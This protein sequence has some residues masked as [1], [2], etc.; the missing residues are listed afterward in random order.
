MVKRK[1][2]MAWGGG[3]VMAV[4]VAFAWRP[5][6]ST[7]RGML[8]APM[9]GGLDACVLTPDLLRKQ[10]PDTTYTRLC[11]AQPASPGELV[12][13]TL[14]RLA[15]ADEIS[16]GGLRMGYTLNVPLLRLYDR[17]AEGFVLNPDRVRRYV[18]TVRDAGYPVILYLY[19]NHFGSGSELEEHL[20]ADSRNLLKSPAGVLPSDQFHAV[21]VRPWSFVEADNEITRLRQ[22]AIEA[23]LG[24]LCN[25]PRRAIQKVEGVTLLGELHHLFPDFNAG[26]G[27]LDRYLVSDYS[28]TSVQGF[29]RYLAQR[30]GAVSALNEY[31]GGQYANFEAVQ[32]P[33]KDIR[34]QALGS[35]FEHLDAYAHGQL[36]VSGWIGQVASGSTERP[37][38]RIYVDGALVGRVRADK[39]RQDVLLA[40]PGLK[41]A[42][43][44]WNFA[45]DFSVLPAGVHSVSVVLEREGVPTVLLTR[46]HISVMDRQQSTPKAQPELPIAGLVP[47]PVGLLFHQDEPRDQ[48]AYYFNPLARLWLEYRRT[49]VMA[50]LSQFARQAQAAGACLKPDRFY[51][52]QIL[53]FANPGWD[54]SKYAVGEDLAV[55]ADV[56]LGIS[57]YGE[58]SYGSSFFEWFA[59]T[60]RQAYGV[61][62]F[63]PMRAMDP[64]ELRTLLERHQA[65]H[66]RFVSFFMESEGLAEDPG[67]KPNPHSFNV[68]NK[69]FGSDV[70]Y[71]SVQQVMRPAAAAGTQP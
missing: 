61:T 32:P 50:Y 58:A 49:Q 17:S 20:A 21:K 8:L 5:W 48:F 71:R 14:G 41:T 25:L 35:F 69:D 18:A 54:P 19:S 11:S 4:L 42:D 64:A 66:A 60:R 7:E 57:L 62:E 33:S 53:P 70:L 27:Y 15:G 2:W 68:L 45:L 13:R 9:I 51:S 34:R 63:H 10:E 23:V 52:H 3:A 55:P 28:A 12:R 6:A 59:R 36:P 31:L 30:Y 46:R 26:M 56:Q 40:H 24:E 29:R 47:A 67:S 44:G 38:V 43:V 16:P 39:G 22:R 37:W 1:T 65:H